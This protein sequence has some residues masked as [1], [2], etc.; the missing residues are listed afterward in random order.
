MCGK[1]NAECSK[2]SE[3]KTGERK[4]KK[5]AKYLSGILCPPYQSLFWFPKCQFFASIFTYFT[6]SLNSRPFSWGLKSRKMKKQN[7]FICY[8]PL[9]PSS[10]SGVFQDG[11]DWVWPLEPPV[12]TKRG[13]K[14]PKIGNA[15]LHGLCWW[16]LRIFQGGQTIGAYLTECLSFLFGGCFLSLPLSLHLLL[17]SQW[18]HILLYIVWIDCN[19]HSDIPLYLLTT[20]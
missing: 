9:S 7:F 13:T 3:L 14:K 8:L 16:M 18:N 2:C 15:S 12:R 20:G 10:T 11:W 6:R 4:W 17:P 19:S 5:L 1:D